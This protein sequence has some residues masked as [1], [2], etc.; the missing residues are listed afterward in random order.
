MGMVV[1]WFMREVVVVVIFEGMVVVWFMREVVVVVVVMVGIVVVW[2]MRKM[3]SDE[4]KRE[5]EYREDIRR[6]R[7]VHGS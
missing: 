4:G 5:R 7:S 2:F 3:Q 1:V 6:R